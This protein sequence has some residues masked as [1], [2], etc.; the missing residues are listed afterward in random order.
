V[1]TSTPPLRRETGGRPA[2]APIA[3]YDAARSPRARGNGDDADGPARPVFQATFFVPRPGV[4]PV[5]SHCWRGLM[6]LKTAPPR[7][8]KMAVIGTKRE[9][10]GRAHGLDY[11]DMK[12]P[13]AAGKSRISA[14]E[15][16]T[17]ITPVL[18][19]TDQGMPDPV[20]LRSALRRWAFNPPH[21]HDDMPADIRAAL[22]WIKRV[23]L[24]LTALQDDKIVRQVL[25]TLALKLDGTA[26]SPDYLGARPFTC[27]ASTDPAGPTVQTMHGR[28]PWPSRIAA[29]S[30]AACRC[31]RAWSAA[32]A[33]AG[34]AAATAWRR[35][36]RGR[37][38]R[39]CAG[40]SRGR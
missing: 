9:R 38:P 14:V 4:G 37:R 16:L 19:R 12:W 30:A 33:A 2:R 11:I 21:R 15:T 18:V 22:S 1:G 7:F 26:A 6:Q 34:R 13:A 28:S 8:R 35:R 23:S 20:I 27:P 29:S 17:A 10:L 3:Q 39:G 36:R 40:R 32:G 24:P 5:L 25:D 31:Q